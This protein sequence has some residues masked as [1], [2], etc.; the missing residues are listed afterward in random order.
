MKQTKQLHISEI[1][2][3]RR[4]G[5][6]AGSPNKMRSNRSEELSI[7][8]L[9]LFSERNFSSVTIKDIAKAADV[10]TALI[11]YY[12]KNKEDLFRCA[13]EHAI[14]QAFK[15]FR[16]LQVRH[17]NPADI[18]DDWLSNHVQLYAPIHKFVKVS[19]DYSGSKTKIALIDRQ[20]RQF[21]DEE[22]RIL[23]E[24]IRLGI[25][26][27]RFSKVDPVALA[28]FISTYLD[29]IMVRSVIQNDFELD[30]AIKGLRQN[31]WA[32]LRYKKTV[33]GDFQTV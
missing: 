3:T 14:D 5:R 33:M 6:P 16:Q 1:Q 28:S 31:I 17:D 23:S 32:Q 20:I 29:G 2:D 30:Q 11:Y 12:F 27:G 4:R 26:T 8:A 9:N 22:R 13:I 25:Q 15:N 10:N 7:V 24:C 19:L 18:I 21:Y